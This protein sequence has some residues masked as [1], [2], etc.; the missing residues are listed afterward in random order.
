MPIN[1][2]I[3]QSS[4]VRI[5]EILKLVPTDIYVELLSVATLPSDITSELQLPVKSGEE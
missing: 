4:M 1:L 5:V 2:M 3:P